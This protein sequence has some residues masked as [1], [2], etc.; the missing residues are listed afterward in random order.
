MEDPETIEL[1]DKKLPILEVA[2]SIFLEHGFNAATTDMIQ[3]EAGISK[4]TM[5]AC[6]PNKKAMF[7]AAIEQQCSI[8][9]ATIQSIQTTPGNIAKTLADIGMSYLQIVLSPTG[10]A[11]YRVVVAEASRFP[12]LA[13]R[14]YLT[15]PKSVISMVAARLREAAQSGEINVQTTGIT[16]AAALFISMVRAEGQMEALTHPDSRPSIAQMENWVQLAVSTFLSAFG[17]K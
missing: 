13:R 16:A 9:A 2:T 5:Y 3:R 14:F 17:H 4:A 11:L 15:G 6:F 1:D 10:L 12:N 7:A 8:M